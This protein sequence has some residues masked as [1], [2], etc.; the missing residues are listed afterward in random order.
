ML[1]LEYG[2]KDLF[3]VKLVTDSQCNLKEKLGHVSHF[4]IDEYRTRQN[5]FIKCH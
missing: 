1:L 5:S 2:F 4:V 3:N